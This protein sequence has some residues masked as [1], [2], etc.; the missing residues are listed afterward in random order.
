MALLG[1]IPYGNETP[2]KSQPRFIRNASGRFESRW[3]TVKI[4]EDSPALMFKGMA[5]STL[6]VWVAHGE[7]RYVVK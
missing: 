1:W 2:A 5:G 3:S 6:G 7:G 4:M